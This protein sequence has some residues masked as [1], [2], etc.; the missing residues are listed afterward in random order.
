MRCA[1]VRSSFMILCFFGPTNLQKTKQTQLTYKTEKA[2]KSSFWVALI[3][4]IILRHY[5]LNSSME[6]HVKLCSS[7]HLLDHHP[8]KAYDPT[9]PEHTNTLNRF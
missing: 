4:Q 9:L 1:W 6:A 8:I 2:F 3:K 5:M 7:P